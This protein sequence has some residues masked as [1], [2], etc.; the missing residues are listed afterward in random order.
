MDIKVVDIKR[1]TLEQC[2]YF[3]SL[4]MFFIVHDGK[5]KGFTR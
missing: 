5:I 4:G 2:I 3:S 1:I